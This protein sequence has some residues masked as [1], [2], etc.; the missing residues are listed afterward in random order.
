M[1][2][3][4]ALLGVFFSTVVMYLIAGIAFVG[5]VFL[6]V[7]VGAVAVLFLFVIMLLN[8]KSLTSDERLVQHPTQV[9]AILATIILLQQLHSRVMNAVDSSISDGF[10][11]DASIEPTTGSAVFRYVR[12]QAM[13]INTLTSLYTLH[14]VLL[15]V[16]TAI[17]LAALL[18]AIILATVTTERATSTYDIHTYSK[19][20]SLSLSSM[21]VLGT[22]IFVGPSSTVPVLEILNCLDC[23][24]ELEFPGTLVLMS[25]YHCR[26][27]DEKR[28]LITN[29]RRWQRPARLL[30]DVRYRLRAQQTFYSRGRLIRRRKTPKLH[31]RAFIR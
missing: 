10:L 6:I 21:L 13:D 26:V 31:R 24:S 11:R 20:N 12:F 23:L 28:F 19:V 5:L 4:L 22:F 2:A 30:N 18:G 17:L 29:Y 27:T 9:A 25:Y 14:S 7:Y 8:V 15:L 3:L 1:H 16:I